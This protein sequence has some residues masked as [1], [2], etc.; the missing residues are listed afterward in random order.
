MFGLS[1][2]RPISKGQLRPLQGSFSK[3]RAEMRIGGVSCAFSY[4]LNEVR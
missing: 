1:L 2:D 4:R 3:Y